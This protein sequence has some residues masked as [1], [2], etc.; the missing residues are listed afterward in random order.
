[1]S[2]RENDPSRQ[3]D[4]PEREVD[5]ASDPEPRGNPDVDQEDVE[6]GREQIEKISGN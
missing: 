2:E 1:M 5:P 6:R 4:A 3:V